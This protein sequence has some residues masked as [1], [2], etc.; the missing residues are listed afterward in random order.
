[1]KMI[2]I[3]LVTNQVIFV[4]TWNILAL[5]PVQ[6][7]LFLDWKLELAFHPVHQMIFA[8]GVQ[9]PLFDATTVAGHRIDEDW[10]EL[11]ENER[12]SE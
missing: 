11:K 4:E 3:L 2:R 10:K 12:K 6:L 8:A 1:M 9:H 5:I 7:Y